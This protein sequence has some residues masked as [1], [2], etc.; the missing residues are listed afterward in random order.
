M[1]FSFSER[2]RS[3][4]NKINIPVNSE[5]KEHLMT[6]LYTKNN[7]LIKKAEVMS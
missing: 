7:A 2:K 1:L 5:G 4:R 3:A 6:M